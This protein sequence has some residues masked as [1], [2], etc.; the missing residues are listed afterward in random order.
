M[1]VSWRFE[2]I[3]L[4][5]IAQFMNTM[6]ILIKKHIVKIILWINIAIIAISVPIVDWLLD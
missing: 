1:I 6:I 4:L 3:I 2:L 5:T